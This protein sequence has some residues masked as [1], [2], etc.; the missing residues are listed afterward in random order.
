[1]TKSHPPPFCIREEPTPPSQ[2][3]SLL[4]LVAARTVTSP[5]EPDI[6]PVSFLSPTKVKRTADRHPRGFRETAHGFQNTEFHR[7][8]CCF[9]VPGNDVN[10][11][12]LLPTARSRTSGSL[13]SALS[14]SRRSL[15]NL[16]GSFANWAIPVMAMRTHTIYDTEIAP[17]WD[18]IGVDHS[19]TRRSSCPRGRPRFLFEKFSPKRNPVRLSS[20]LALRSGYLTS[21]SLL[22]FYQM[23]RQTSLLDALQISTVPRPGNFSPQCP[24]NFAQGKAPLRLLLSKLPPPSWL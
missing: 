19:A 9:F 13:P 18:A 17:S 12:V 1:L 15:M 21:Y 23:C 16:S 8:L 5:P 7:T 4:L 2:K 14:A 24:M 6:H 22:P 3:T 11:K 20:D 10:C